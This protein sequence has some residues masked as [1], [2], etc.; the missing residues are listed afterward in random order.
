MRRILAIS[1]L[2]AASVTVMR[3]QIAKNVVLEK[4]GP[5]VNVK[6]DLDLQAAKPGVN[7]TVLLVPQLRSASVNKDL[8]V[9]GLYSRSQWFN[10]RRDKKN[11]SGKEGERQ[12]LS[13]GAPAVIV[14]E[15]QFPYEEWMKG[16]SLV[17]QK[18]VKGCCGKD[19]E[20]V[21]SIPLANLYVPEEP[22]PV[23]EEVV[24]KET[25]DTVVEETP[26]VKTLYGRAYIEFAPNGTKID[27]DFHS[28]ARELGIL[29]ASLD[30][31]SRIPGAGIRKIR[32]K[33][34]S[35]PE[36]AYPNNLRLAQART[37]AVKNY[38]SKAYNLPDEVFEIDFEAENWEGLREYVEAS[39]LPDKADMLKIIDSDRRPEGKEYLLK[40]YHPESWD[41]LRAQC[42]PFLRRTDYSIEYEIVER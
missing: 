42:M 31:V 40:R 26:V 9:V 28:N 25:R 34:Y 3:A 2:L 6:M 17:L 27:P 19:K 11:A 30:S 38:V 1:L 13:R 8:Q 18:R 14:Y 39:K 24:V 22:A 35:S 33:S 12:L 29:R 21:F 4:D 20:Q 10:Y 23:Q 16:A 37:R 7:E 15:T 36:G 41:I 32:I 5:V